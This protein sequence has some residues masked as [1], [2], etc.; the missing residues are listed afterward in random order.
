MLSELTLSELQT[1]SPLIGEEVFD[2]LSLE[3]SVAARSHVGGTAPEQ[4]RKAIATARQYL[5]KSR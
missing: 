5:P 3:G 1:F 2:I 4:V